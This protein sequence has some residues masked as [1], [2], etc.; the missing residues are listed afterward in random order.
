MLE[1]AS[2]MMRLPVA[3]EISESDFEL[4]DER[5]RTPAITVVFCR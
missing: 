2:G 4:V 3:V 5:S 1:I